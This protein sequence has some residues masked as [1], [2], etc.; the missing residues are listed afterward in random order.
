MSGPRPWRRL[1]D[2]TDLL[3]DG[4]YVQSEPE[5]KRSLVGST[6][7]RFTSLSIRYTDFD[8]FHHV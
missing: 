1:L 5:I 8:P 4:P 3:V 2:A 7:Q 6:N